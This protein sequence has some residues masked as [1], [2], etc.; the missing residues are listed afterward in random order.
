[1]I[2]FHLCSQQRP[3]PHTACQEITNDWTGLYQ[4][5]GFSRAVLSPILTY[6]PMGCDCHRAVRLPGN[7]AVPARNHNFASL[8]ARLKPMPWHE[9]RSK[10]IHVGERCVV[11]EENRIVLPPSPRLPSGANECRG[12]AAGAQFVSR[13]RLQWSRKERTRASAPDPVTHRRWLR[14]LVFGSPIVAR[15][16]RGTL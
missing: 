13:V 6:A 7:C 10:N 15:K 2:Q 11:P 9:S 5:I 4:D 1:M 16:C 8:T 14:W 12:Y 3:P